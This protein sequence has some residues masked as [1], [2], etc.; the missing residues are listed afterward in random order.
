MT[1]QEA[2]KIAA[3]EL[4]DLI[5]TTWAPEDYGYTEDEN[6]L[7]QEEFEKIAHRLLNLLNNILYPKPRSD[8]KPKQVKPRKSDEIFNR[9]NHNIQILRDVLQAER[10]QDS[11]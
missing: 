2:K 5:D 9:M 6:E 7:I 3:R 8:N 1:K 10:Q 11:D 4:H